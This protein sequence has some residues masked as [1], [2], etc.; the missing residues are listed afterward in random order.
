M[1]TT[2]TFP[3]VSRWLFSVALVLICMLHQSC[4]KDEAAPAPDAC[5]DAKKVNAAY[6]KVK[7]FLAA[8][9]AAY[10][11]GTIDQS[12]IG[13]YIDMLATE[14]RMEYFINIISL[15]A[16]ATVTNDDGTQW[17]IDAQTVSDYKQALCNETD[18][19]NKKL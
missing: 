3:S 7:N 1:K 15:G 12:K 5:Y 10:K 13:L 4:K 11:D 18:D 16:G 2:K 8:N 9:E 6:T 14:I 17:T 19:V